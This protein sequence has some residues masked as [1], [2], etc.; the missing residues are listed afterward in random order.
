[1]S[2]LV[3]MLQTQVDNEAS[4]AKEAFY[5]KALQDLTLFKSKTNAALL[6]VCG[7]GN[8]AQ[9]CVRPHLSTF[10]RCID[11]QN[12]DLVQ[13]ACQECNY[14]VRHKTNTNKKQ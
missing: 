4:R 11:C 14:L 7:T 9:Y 1:M 5:Q 8:P 12:T 3:V 6:Q 10:C 13:G 2:D